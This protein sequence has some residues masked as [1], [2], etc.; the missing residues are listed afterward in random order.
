LSARAVAATISKPGATIPKPDATIS[1]PRTTKSKSTATKS[2]YILGIK[3][4][5]YTHKT[6]KV[7]LRPLN[8]R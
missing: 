3:S 7:H 8:S 6:A 4:T 2:K 1:K 5:A